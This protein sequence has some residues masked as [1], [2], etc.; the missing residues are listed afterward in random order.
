MEL[1]GNTTVSPHHRN[2]EMRYT[3]GKRH[4]RKRRL[5]RRQRR[6]LKRFQNS[7]SPRPLDPPI[8]QRDRLLAKKRFFYDWS[9]AKC[10]PPDM[11]LIPNIWRELKR[12]Q[13]AGKW[14]K[15]RGAVDSPKNQGVDGS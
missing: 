8:E 6:N 15:L 2:C 12:K 14:R 5:N 7:S 1:R 11:A 10:P 3:R 4:A 13:K 9:D